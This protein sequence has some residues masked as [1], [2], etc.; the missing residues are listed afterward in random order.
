MRERGSDVGAVD[1]MMAK[2]DARRNQGGLGWG[3]R[4]WSRVLDVTIGYGYRPMR[5][6][7][8]IFFFV[9]L[10]SVLFGL[11]YRE[12][13]ITPTEPEAYDSFRQDR[14]AA[15]PLSAVQRGRLLAGKFPA[16]GRSASGDLLAAQSAPWDGRPDARA[17][18]HAAPM[19]L[20]GAYSCRMDN[21][22]AA[23]RGAFGPGAPRLRL[24]GSPALAALEIAREG[25]LDRDWL[26]RRETESAASRQ[27]RIRI[28]LRCTRSGR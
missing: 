8:W 24:R 2:E 4:L 17:L 19:V 23:R 14:R 3:E 18:G 7:W 10:G 26:A 16:G 15:A 6:L 13:A 5:A 21:H 11:G 28:S 1:V 20:V 25:M 12:R 9:A 27:I 22:A